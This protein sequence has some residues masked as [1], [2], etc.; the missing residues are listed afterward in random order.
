MNLR[1]QARKKL[2]DFDSTSEL[3]AF[4]E[5]GTDETLF[6]HTHQ[7]VIRARVRNVSVYD[8]AAPFMLWTELPVR[9]MMTCTDVK[10]GKD[11]DCR[12]LRNEDVTAA[13]TALKRKGLTY[14]FKTLAKLQKAPVI[15]TIGGVERRVR[16]VLAAVTADMP[17][18]AALLGNMQRWSSNGRFAASYIG[19][20]SPPAEAGLTEDEARFD[21]NASSGPLIGKKRGA[22]ETFAASLAAT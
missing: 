4:V 7:D 12:Q 8:R 11:L 17:V 10:T 15:C 20:Y 9:E 14:A 13:I 22:S 16:F 19:Y 18:R 3:L 5:I 21:D 2:Q 6:N 1:I